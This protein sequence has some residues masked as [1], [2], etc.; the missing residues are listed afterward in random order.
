MQLTPE[1]TVRLQLENG[2]TIED[3]ADVQQLRDGDRLELLPDPQAPPIRPH[4]ARFTHSPTL[5]AT[6]AP[7]LQM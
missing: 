1:T 6:A 2:A 5:D 3:D 7:D 4:L